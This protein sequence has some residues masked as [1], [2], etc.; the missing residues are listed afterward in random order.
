MNVKY[1]HY[2]LWFNVLSNR[3]L[4]LTAITKKVSYIYIYILHTIYSAQ[5]I[6][7]LPHICT[8][9][10]FNTHNHKQMRIR[11]M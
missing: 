8:L 4:D 11:G 7:K 9:N 10:E 1:K 6:H 2:A 3:T 5:L